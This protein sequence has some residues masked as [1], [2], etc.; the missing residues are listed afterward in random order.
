MNGCCALALV[1]QAEPLNYLALW[2]HLWGNAKGG[3]AE[4][5]K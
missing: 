5:E 4:M 3:K 2:L 1:I